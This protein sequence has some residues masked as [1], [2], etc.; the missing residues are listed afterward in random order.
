MSE[1][2]I[3]LSGRPPKGF[4]V[5]VNGWVLSVQ[6]G[7]GNYCDNYNASITEECRGMRIKHLKKPQHNAEIALWT[8]DEKKEWL[9]VH[10]DTVVPNVPIYAVLR[11]IGYLAAK[12]RT[13]TAVKRYVLQVIA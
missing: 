10:G 12:R 11:I 3:Q 13:A 2:T 8:H 9:K 1:A 5:E 4:H 6:W 7:A